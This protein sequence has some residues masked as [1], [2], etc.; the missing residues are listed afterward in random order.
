MFS[1]RLEAWK[2]LQRVLGEDAV[3]NLERILAEVEELDGKATKGP[4]KI[5]NLIPIDK[6]QV[7]SHIIVQS[8][9]L[10]SHPDYDSEFMARARIL[11]P[12]MAE[13]IEVLEEGWLQSFDCSRDPGHSNINDAFKRAEEIAGECGCQK[14]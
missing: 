12:K 10:S 2:T 1:M 6:F 14:S 7:R 13:I 5:R 3:N 4:W 8:G 11:L 9:Q